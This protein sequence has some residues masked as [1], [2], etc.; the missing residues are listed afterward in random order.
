MEFKL[1][2]NCAYGDFTSWNEYCI[3]HAPNTS[4]FDAIAAAMERRD[5]ALMI[6]DKPA[7]ELHYRSLFSSPPEA[8]EFETQCLSIALDAIDDT[9][10]SFV[11]AGLNHEPIPGYW[12]WLSSQYESTR[13]GIKL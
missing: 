7:E 10:K 3:D 12:N 1:N 4:A 13:W 11:I 5:P 2:T 8:T 9:S 6:N